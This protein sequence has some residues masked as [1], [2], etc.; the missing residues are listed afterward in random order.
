MTHRELGSIFCLV[1]GRTLKRHRKS[2]G[3]TQERLGEVLGVHMESI[4]RKE[5]NTQAVPKVVRLA[6]EL[7]VEREKGK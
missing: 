4:S 5:R 3:W 6:V 7:L 1:K 2:L